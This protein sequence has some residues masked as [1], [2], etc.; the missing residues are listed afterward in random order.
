MQHSQ[1]ISVIDSLCDREQVFKKKI[2]L[3]HTN[4]T[5]AHALRLETNFN[6]YGL[7]KLDSINKEQFD[8][9]QPLS[10]KYLEPV[11]AANR[12]YDRPVQAL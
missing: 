9:R 11:H 8:F 10:S 3:P 12:F 1:S 5:P 4:I 7:E 2:S 6:L